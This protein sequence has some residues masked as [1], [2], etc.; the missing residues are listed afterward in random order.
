MISVLLS[1]Y[2]KESCNNLD[3]ALASLK[4][5]TI[6]P[7]EVVAVFD[8]PLPL[9][10]EKV[11]F[12]SFKETK[13]PVK[14]IRLGKNSGLGIALANGFAACQQDYILRVDTDDINRPIRIEKQLKFIKENPHVDAFGSWIEEFNSKPGDLKRCRRTPISADAVRR[15]A[16]KRNPMNHMTMVVRRSSAIQ[17]GGYIDYPGFEDYYLWFRMLKNE[18]ILENMPEVLVD[19]RVGDG[20]TRRRRGIVYMRKEISLFREMRECKF[21]SHYRYTTN[22]CQRYILRLAPPAVLFVIYWIFLRH[23]VD[24]KSMFT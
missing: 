21:I 24:D 12:D 4:Q 1:L 20:M 13:F 23:K 8:G 7:D 11:F 15:F 6:L 22:I 5:Q 10:L 19:A 16:K 17:A 9:E 3:A 14:V 2:S 18:M